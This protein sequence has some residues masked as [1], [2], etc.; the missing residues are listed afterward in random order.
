MSDTKEL[1]IEGYNDDI[2]DEQLVQIIS[3]KPNLERLRL[4]ECSEITKLPVLP[5]TLTELSIDQCD[6]IRLLGALPVALSNPLPGNLEILDCDMLPKLEK[7]ISPPFLRT[8][9][10]R[11]CEKLSNIDISLSNNLHLL[12]ATNCEN[13]HNIIG[14]IPHSLER[15]TITETK[16]LQPETAQKLLDY[17]H[18]K[19]AAFRAEHSWWPR[20]LQPIAARIQI[21][22]SMGIS[23]NNLFEGGKLSRKHKGTRR[24]RM[25]KKQKGKR[26][27]KKTKNKGKR[28][29]KNKTI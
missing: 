2:N 16:S 5:V 10:C 27:T 28:S 11:N 15:I 25:T 22:H 7:I 20:E 23:K 3:S 26:R 13:L 18:I 8:L 29:K 24:R 12:D 14:N 6:E 4:F 19:D 21:I 1:T 9:V 17:Y